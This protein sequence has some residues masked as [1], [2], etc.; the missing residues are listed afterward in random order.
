MVRSMTSLATNA[1]LVILG[2]FVKEDVV[3][4]QSTNLPKTSSNR[5]SKPKAKNLFVPFDQHEEELW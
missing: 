2:R 5:G 4:L 1:R 3:R